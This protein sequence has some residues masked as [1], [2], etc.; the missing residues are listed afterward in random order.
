MKEIRIAVIAEIRGFKE[1]V[2]DADTYEDPELPIRVKFIR[3][4]D[5][6]QCR[7]NFFHTYILHYTGRKIEGFQKIIDRVKSR[8]IEIK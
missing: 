1:F 5:E 3:I 4:Y 7:G 6:Q 8:I 2:N